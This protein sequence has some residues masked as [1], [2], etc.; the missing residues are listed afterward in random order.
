LFGLGGSFSRGE[1]GERR[2]LFL[3]LLRLWVTDVCVYDDPLMS[4]AGSGVFD[5]ILNR[6]NEL[7]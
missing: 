4:T 1:T 7:S 6:S 5:R 2:L 3:F